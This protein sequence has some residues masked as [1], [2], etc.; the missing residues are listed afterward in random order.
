MTNKSN[1]L[2]KL[3]VIT[4]IYKN[5]QHMEFVVALT[6]A[7]N[8]TQADFT[9][10]NYHHIKQKEIDGAKLTL[11]IAAVQQAIIDLQG[12]GFYVNCNLVINNENALHISITATNNSSNRVAGVCFPANNGISAPVVPPW[13]YS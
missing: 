1:R 11:Q 12:V 2:K 9:I 7:K 10:S 5:L 6:I 4:E 3:E 13:G 8:V